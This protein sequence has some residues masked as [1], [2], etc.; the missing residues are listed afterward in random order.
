[1]SRKTIFGWLI[2]MQLS[3]V[4]VANSRAED[5]RVALTGCALLR[6]LVVT[7]VLEAGLFRVGVATRADEWPADLHTCDRTAY[8]VSEAFSAA[9]A[10][11]YVFLAWGGRAGID[12]VHC[13]STRLTLCVPQRHPA[14]PHASDWPGSFVVDAW[15]AVNVALTDNLPSDDVTGIARFTESSLR[16]SLRHALGMHLRGGRSRY[17]EFAEA[18]VDNARR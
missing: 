12:R 16:P 8:T 13:E 7:E 4:G 5:G 10:E 6:E 3:A 11:M 9:M 1:M 14:F 15:Y 18:R 2:M 17:Y